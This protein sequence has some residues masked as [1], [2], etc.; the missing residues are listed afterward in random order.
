MKLRAVPC[1]EFLLALLFL[2][3]TVVVYYPGYMSPDSVVILGQ[4]RHGVTTNV[5]SPLM[6]YGASPTIF[7]PAPA[8][9]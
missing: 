4:A 3:A 5:Y 1:P 8:A 7:F 6:A 9:C 2:I